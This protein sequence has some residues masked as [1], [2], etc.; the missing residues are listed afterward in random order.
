MMIGAVD[1]GGTKIAVGAID[2]NSH[3]LARL[4]SPTDARSGFADAV[5]RIEAMLRNVSRIAGANLAGIGIGCTGPIDPIEGTIGNV[6]F[7][8]GW[9]GMNLVGELS[10]RFQVEVAMENDADAAAL[11]EARWGSGRGKRNFIYVTVGTGIGAGIILDGK[12]YRG[13]DGFHPD[14]GH[15]VIDASGPACYCGEHGCWEILASGP[16]MAEWMKASVS[17]AGPSERELSAEVICRLAREGD[18]LAGQ[19]VER[20][21]RY[22]GLGLANLVKIFCPDMIALA[23]GVMR[24]ADLFLPAIHRIIA[25]TCSLVPYLKARIEPAHLGADVALSGAA[26]VW[27]HRFQSRGH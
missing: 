25:R 2:E 7:L 18:P 9:E 4:E 22:L 21:A 1:V 6:E 17:T 12:L 5:Q 11:A 19:A 14:I 26:E 23:G 16:A 15:Q 27:R 3:I 10:Q 13:V 24:S 8:P 20:E